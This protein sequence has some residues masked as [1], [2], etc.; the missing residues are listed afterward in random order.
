MKRIG[1]GIFVTLT[2]AFQ[3]YYSGQA[4]L[5]YGQKG[6]TN[7]VAPRK[8]KAIV[9]KLPTDA[10]GVILK[11]GMVKVKAGNKFVKQA[12]GTVTVARIKGGAGIGGKWDC[13]CSKDGSCDLVSNGTSLTCSGGTCKGSCTLS[14]TT[15]RAKTGVLIY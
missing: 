10:E 8:G 6:Q 13:D 7:T 2:L 4:P 12:D 15:T 14:I 11:D 1:I 5:A 3:I 9:S